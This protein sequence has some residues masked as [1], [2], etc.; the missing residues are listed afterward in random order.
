V[1]W[2]ATRGGYTLTAAWSPSGTSARRLCRESGG[3]P[4]GSAAEVA[5]GSGPPAGSGTEAAAPL[6]LL[7]VPDGEIAGLAAALAAC[8]LRPGQVVLHASGAL[9]ATVLAPLKAAGAAVGSWHPLQSLT[10][11]PRRSAALLRGAR[12]AL[13]GDA[14]AVA[15]GREL[16]LAVGAVPMPL[17]AGAK[18][19]YHA[20]A[21][22]T[23]NYL[24]A[25]AAAAQRAW[26]AAGLEPEAALPALLPLMQGALA[27]L[28]GQ[29]LPG[30]LTGPIPRGDAGTVA[31]HL[32]ALA[33]RAPDLLPLYTALGREALR[34]APSARI[35]DL[36]QAREGRLEG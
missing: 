9:D 20:A 30:A 33:E 15:A 2:A 8:R 4:A 32:Q 10:G 26:S 35:A 18:P 22:F 16:T 36:L 14:A 11:A 7:A 23:A 12:V 19:L 25:L 1:A 3:R 24:V 5:L 28:Q 27:H 21:V 6:L 13:E 31:L 34:L 17:P 29:G